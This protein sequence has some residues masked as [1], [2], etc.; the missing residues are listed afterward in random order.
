MENQGI[1]AADKQIRLRPDA[2]VLGYEVGDE[3]KL[4]AADF[5][6]LSDAFLAEIEARYI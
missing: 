5:R 2:S 3:I 4:S 1:L 6:R